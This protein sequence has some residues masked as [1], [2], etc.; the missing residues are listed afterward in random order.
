MPFPKDPFAFADALADVLRLP[1]EALAMSYLYMNKYLRFHRSSTTPDPLDP[2]T[3][4]LSTISLASKSTESPRRLSS[5]LLP[6]HALL[7]PSSSTEQQPLVIPSPTYD[8]LRATLVQADLIL[9]R[10][11]GFQL[12]L[13]SPLEYLQRYLERA[14]EGVDTVG[15]AFDEWDR[16]AKDEYGV[17]SEIMEGRMG[18]RCRAKAVD[19]CRNYELANLFSAR[20][21]A[22]GAVYVVLEASRLR[23]EQGVSEWVKDIGSGKVD[24]EDFEEV[25]AILRKT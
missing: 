16:E 11:L 22:L 1:D 9:L 14:M 17:L 3:L 25:V 21:V 8:T 10:V 18:R 20:A 19:A 12:H 13:P 6:A 15:E 24:N 5:I 4:S 7:H 2:Y 23:I